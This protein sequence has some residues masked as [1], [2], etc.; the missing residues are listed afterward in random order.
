MKL[1]ANLDRRYVP[2][3]QPAERYLRLQ[4]E[5]PERILSTRRLPLNLAL[6]ID[7]SGSMAGIK[8][9]KAREAVV[10]CLRHLAP[11][12][13]VAVVAYDHEVRVVSPSRL[14]T[15]DAKSKLINEVQAIQSGGNTNLGGGWLTG[16][17][18]VAQH[19]S[20]AGYLSRAILLS[21]GLAN[22]GITDTNELAHHATQLRLRGISTTTIGIGADYN[23]DLLQQMALK[24]GGHFY[25]IEDARQIP[26]LLQSELGEVLATSARRVDLEMHLPELVRAQL[27]NN[28][29]HVREGK[30]FSVRL[31]DMMAG[32]ARSLVFKLEVSPGPLGSMLPIKWRVSYTDVETDRTLRLDGPE[33]VL[34]YA[35]E[36]V[37][38]RET[39]DPA[40]MEDT[41]LLQAAI[42]REEALAYDASGNYAMSAQSLQS[43]ATY[44][45]T[46]APASPAAQADAAALDAEAAQAPSGFSA[47]KR[48]ALHYS[49]ATR[50]QSRKK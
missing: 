27:L 49:Q 46:Y 1:S 24:G 25:F 45:R 19:L 37:C 13:R 40:V 26:D 3:G 9:D 39:A 10:F 30:H 31:D 14:L 4:L 8:L 5:A 28:F 43:A 12:D 38:S 20:E 41:A 44:L 22:E 50:R 16:A 34:T 29:E 36:E 21:D 48:K 47:L 35:S 23:E 7:R 11:T 2:A 32:E 18:E 33:V 15:S 17:E 6:V 42:A